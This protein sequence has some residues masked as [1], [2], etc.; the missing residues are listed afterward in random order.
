MGHAVIPASM[1]EVAR[2]RASHNRAVFFP[3]RGDAVLTEL[4]HIGIQE[5]AV[6]SDDHGDP[7]P[8][9]VALA[10]IMST[11]AAEQYASDY[12]NVNSD[13]SVIIP[14]ASEADVTVRERTVKIEVSAERAASIIRGRWE[15]KSELDRKGISYVSIDA[16]SAPKLR[17]PVARATD[18]KLVTK[19]FLTDHRGHPME[20]TRTLAFPEPVL[21]ASMAEARAAGLDLMTGNQAI[22]Q[23]EVRAHQVREH[24]GE[25]SRALVTITRPAQ[26]VTLT[27]T[28]TE[29]TVKAKAKPE[30]YYVA[31]DYH[32]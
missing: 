20:T 2:Q 15:A 28:Y 18:G 31:F 24:G 3:S 27:V 1:M 10:S 4:L 12:S 7:S 13:K 14:V 23:L 9:F 21:H 17:K 30:S 19:Y 6:S 22:G 16:V 29:H 26:N 11:A 8:G 25:P 32:R 5:W